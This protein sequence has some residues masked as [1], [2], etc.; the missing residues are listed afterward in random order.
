MVWEELLI[1]FSI[2]GFM[3]VFVPDAVWSKIFL[4]NA[5]GSIPEWL[6]VIENALVAPFVAALTFIGSMGNIPLA[7]FSSWLYL[8]VA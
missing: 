1:G 4:I 2:A 8:P 6:R 3:A 5:A 7:T